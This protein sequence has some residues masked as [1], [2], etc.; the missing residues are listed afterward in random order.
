MSREILAL[1]EALASEKNVEP[2]VVFEALEVA[3]G[4]AAKKKADREH[5]NLEVRIN[6]DT[7]EYRTVRKWLIV[8]DLDYTYPEL[9]KTIE[10]IQEEIPGIDINVGDYFEEDIPNITKKSWKTWPSA[11]KPRKLPSKSFCSASAMPN[12][13]RF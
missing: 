13:S 1:V 5:M 11:A 9:E 3:L 4:I 7:G 6:R 8:E 10:Q 2:D 12:A